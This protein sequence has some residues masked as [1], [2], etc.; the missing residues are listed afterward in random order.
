MTINYKNT[1]SHGKIS[2]KDTLACIWEGS[3][4]RTPQK[5]DEVQKP[6]DDY[7]PE[8][9]NDYLEQQLRQ[10][11]AEKQLLQKPR[12][13]AGPSAPSLAGEPLTGEP[14][15]GL[16][17][18]EPGVTDM[19]DL[20]TTAVATTAGALT[21]FIRNPVARTL[22]I[23]TIGLADFI[24]RSGPAKSG[25]SFTNLQDTTTSALADTVAATVAQLSM[26]GLSK[27]TG[28]D[29]AIAKAAAEGEAAASIYDRQRSTDAVRVNKEL[30]PK[31]IETLTQQAA[32]TRV[33]RRISGDGLPGEPLAPLA[34]ST[35]VDPSPF[36]AG[37]VTTN[38]FQSLETIN[39]PTFETFP[40]AKLELPQEV[41]SYK[42]PMGGYPDN[43]KV[44][45]WA[46]TAANYAPP[47][48]LGVI[49]AVQAMSPG[50]SAAEVAA[51]R[52]NNPESQLDLIQKAGW[53][54]RLLARL[55]PAAQSVDGMEVLPPATDQTTQG[56]AMRTQSPQ[57][58]LPQT[59]EQAAKLATKG[60]V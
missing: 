43:S 28:K 31:Q 10:R 22:L 14:A 23:P 21:G 38:P 45:P 9:T 5:A 56:R 26:R 52:T 50:Q 25:Q 12:E 48:A 60:R 55:S 34:S 11:Y 29:L 20:Q 32:A 57:P 59:K 18:T 17:Y 8:S 47:V 42:V 53:A 15:R 33:P 24:Y 6:A 40:N 51:M 16:I 3:D 49:I 46:K 27:N 19:E 1:S 7:N 41:V 35:N 30:N 54:P 4:P 44:P 58:P 36:R 2:F 13:G 37:K 39:K